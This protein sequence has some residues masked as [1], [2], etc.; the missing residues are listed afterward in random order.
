MSFRSMIASQP[1]SVARCLDAARTEVERIDLGPFASGLI[2]VT[3]IGASFAAAL[4]VAAELARRGRRA[5]A[6]RSVDLIDSYDFAD[7]IV[8]LSHRGKSIEP[9]D[10]LRAHPATPALAITNSPDSPVAKAAG[11]HLR[12]ANE[13]DATPS[14][15]GYTGTLAAAGVLIDRLCGD[16]STDW[17]ELPLLVAD[18]LET[19][20]QWMVRLGKLFRDRRAID[21][22]G[23][24]S[25]LGTAEE[26]SLLLREAARIPTG[27]TDTRHFLHGPVEAM[28]ART[29]VVLFGDG[30]EL[31]LAGQLE[32]IGCPALLVTTSD[33]TAVKGS[34]TVLRVPA[35]DNRV[36]RGILEIVPAQ[37]LAA[38][39]SDDAGLTDTKFRYP[40]TD[41]KLNN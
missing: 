24:N 1:E 31:R 10:S 26:A 13:L 9:A 20:A 38:E 37:L 19:T 39:L 2:A 29:G 15:T 33:E 28:D 14:S 6:V 40:Q 30:R 35:R 18:V 27:V 16:S 25:C 21:C 8:A 11:Q 41:T 22:V 23:A 3:G 17:M 36:T 4:V 7:S 12:I 34:L 32:E 5:V